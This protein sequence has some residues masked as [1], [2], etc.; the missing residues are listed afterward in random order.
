[1]PNI[2]PG[3]TVLPDDQSD[4]IILNTS[5]VEAMVGEFEKGPDDKPIL[6]NSKQFLKYFGTMDNA[7]NKQSYISAVQMLKTAQSCQIINVTKNALYGG[8]GVSATDVIP[9]TTGAS[10][11]DTYDFDTNVIEVIDEILDTGDGSSLTLLGTT[12]KYPIVPASITFTYTIAS[13]EYTATANAAGIITGTNISSGTIDYNTGEWTITFAIAPDLGVDITASYNVSYLFVLIARSKKAWSDNVGIKVTNSDGLVNESFKISIYELQTDGTNK[14]IQEFEVSRD[15]T[16][17]SGFGKPIYINDI[18]ENEDYHFYCINNTAIANTVMPIVGTSVV[19]AGGGIDGD[20]PTSVEYSAAVDTFYSPDVDFD[21]FIGAG[22]TDKAVIDSIND[23]VTTRYKEAYIDT[24]SGSYSVVISW[25]TNT[26]NI[27]SMRLSAYAPAQ[28]VTYQGTNYYCPISALAGM[29][30]AT[31]VKNGQPFMPPAG[32][33][34][35]RGTL[36]VVKQDLVYTDDECRLLY[37]AGVNAIRYFKNYGNV[38]FSDFTLQKKLSATSYQN[39]VTTLNKMITEF[40]K[41]LLVINFKV[42]NDRTFQQ[43]E[44]LINSFMDQLSRYDGTVETGWVVDFGDNDDI[45]RD[46]GKVYVKLIFV[47]Q[48]LVR[49][50]E[51]KLTY[52]NNQMFA[53]VAGA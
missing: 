22:I 52:V 13:T 30:K 40:E 33:G 3:V 17:K 5:I 6:V 49:E 44:A 47:F 19:Y 8:L 23:L 28:W 35:D 31:V 29:Q 24:I 41:A 43:I 42:I 21:V 25:I 1:M 18:F 48:N 39:S 7:P 15:I 10:Q 2:F 26:L 50:I 45:S 53:E 11:K 32:I 14:F 16:K 34:S 4:T 12:E 27:D 51:L 20:T 37:Q 38:I 46:A 9:F 36:N